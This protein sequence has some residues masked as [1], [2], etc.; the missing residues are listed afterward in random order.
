MT[1]EEAKNLKPGDEVIWDRSKRIIIKAIRLRNYIKDDRFTTVIITASD[2]SVLELYPCQL[3]LPGTTGYRQTLTILLK[4]GA[5]INKAEACDWF[6]ECFRGNEDILDWSVVPQGSG[7]F[8]I[9]PVPEEI[10]IPENYEEGNLVPANIN[11]SRPWACKCCH[12]TIWL[13]YEKL[14]EIGTPVCT[15]CDEE[16]ELED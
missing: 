3:S 6:A 10:E 7:P 13:S 8:P 9:F 2:D 15:N 11:C 1:L 4:P 16:M 5:A 12:F 14:A